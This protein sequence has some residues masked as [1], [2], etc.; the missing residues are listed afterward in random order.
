MSQQVWKIRQKSTR[1]F[2]VGGNLHR[3]FRAWSKKGKSWN[4][5]NHLKNH[6]NLNV[7]FYRECQDDIEIVK[8]E[9][10]VSEKDTISMREMLDE[11]EER[12]QQKQLNRAQRRR[13][14][15]LIEL[16]REQARIKHEL[17]ELK[18]K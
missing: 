4:Q 11:R 17:E 13:E 18:G 6:L 14:T 15:R 10:V 7:E 12:Y 16:E 9:M 3:G 1:L 5:L 2:S 8:L